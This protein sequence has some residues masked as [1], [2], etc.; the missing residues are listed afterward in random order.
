MKMVKTVKEQYLSVPGGNVWLMTINPEKQKP[1][2]WVLHG[3]PGVPH[4]YLEPLA[5]LADERPVVF[6]DQLGCGNSEKPGDSSLWVLDRFVEELHS[7]LT[8]T[9]TT[10]FHLLGQSW[11]SMLAIEYM[12]RKKPASVVSLTFSGAVASTSRFVEDQKRYLQQMPE[13][14]RKAIEES[15]R[16]QRYDEAYQKALM[17]FYN[18]YVCRMD[19]WPVCLLRSMNKT[20]V[21]YQTMWGPSEFTQTGNLSDFERVDRLCEIDRPVLFTCGRYDES[22]PETN[23]YYKKHLPGSRVVVFEDASHEHHLEKQ[24]LYLETVR[25][26]LHENDPD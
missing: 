14:D 13:N 3:G 1:A 20:G 5:E 11:G 21:P 18:R 6:Y 19:P 7:L 26:F 10:R 8:Q 2:L 16:K 23:E 25:A 15:E 4:D 22:T 9:N 17:V 24:T 12:L